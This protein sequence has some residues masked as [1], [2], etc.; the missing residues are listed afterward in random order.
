ML[1]AVASC[2]RL[3][4]ERGFESVTTSHAIQ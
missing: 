4:L 1:D 2:D 3:T